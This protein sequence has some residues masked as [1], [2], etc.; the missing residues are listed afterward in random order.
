M[1]P[2]TENHRYLAPVI[3]NLSRIAFNKCVNRLILLESSDKAFEASMTRAAAHELQFSS[4]SLLKTPSVFVDWSLQGPQ[5]LCQER[6]SR[7]HECPRCMC[8]TMIATRVSR[9]LPRRLCSQENLLRTLVARVVG[10]ETSTSVDVV[11]RT[12]KIA[13]R[14]LIRRFGI[15]R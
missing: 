9:L 15:R 13:T 8:N 7:F 5:S 2:H 14:T 6:R 4:A 3:W 10:A 1:L 11:P 12:L